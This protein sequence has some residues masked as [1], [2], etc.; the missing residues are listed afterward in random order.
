MYKFLLFINY[1][2]FRLIQ[3]ILVLLLFSNCTTTENATR[4]EKWSW[5]IQEEDKIFE[6]SIS[7]FGKLKPLIERNK[8]YKGQEPTIE[9]YDLIHISSQNFAED[10]CGNILAQE[11]KSSKD[12]VERVNRY[13]STKN[14]NVETLENS[15]NSNSPDYVIESCQSVHPNKQFILDDILKL[16]KKIRENLDNPQKGNRN[17]RFKLL[18]NRI[19]SPIVNE[20]SEN[21][22]ELYKKRETIIQKYRAFN[23]NVSRATFNEKALSRLAL[24]LAYSFS[25]SRYNQPYFGGIVFVGL[26]SSANLLFSPRLKDNDRVAFF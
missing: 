25:L 26:L 22:S 9:E 14:V 5:I 13:I 12:W 7:E 23:S 4:L 18:Q 2:F 16:V 20:K 21:Q 24:M 11:I 17:A 8:F 15:F 6:S 1:F 10:T 19:R 3:I